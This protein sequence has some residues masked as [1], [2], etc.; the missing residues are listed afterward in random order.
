MFHE[1]YTNKLG[2]EFTNVIEAEGVDGLIKLFF[3]N[4]FF[5]IQKEIFVISPLLNLILIMKLSFS[6]LANADTC[7]LVLI[8]QSK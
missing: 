5:I 2:F 1:A 8:L 7:L 3:N 6:I 4:E